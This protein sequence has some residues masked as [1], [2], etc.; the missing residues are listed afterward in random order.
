VSPAVP[1]RDPWV[2]HQSRQPG[3]FHRIHEHAGQNFS[4]SA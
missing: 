3:T 1:A 2:N 4:V